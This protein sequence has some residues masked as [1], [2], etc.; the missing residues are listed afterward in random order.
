M[1]VEL[2]PNCSE[3]AAT[4][5]I[6]SVAYLDNYISTPG[7]QECVNY[8]GDIGASPLNGTTGSYAFN[9][10]SGHNFVVVVNAVNTPTSQCSNYSAK[11]S[12]FFDDTPANGA[13]PACVLTP[14][15]TTS[16]LWPPNHNLINVGLASPSTG[17]CPANRQVTVYSDEDDVTPGT[18][19][20]HSPDAKNI[21][22][23]TLRL[24]SERKDSGDG[25]V[26][27]IVVKTSDGTGN[28]AF[29]C[30]T[31]TVPTGQSSAEKNA[32]AAQAAAAQ[33]FCTN[34]AGA[35]PAGF[36]VVGDGPVIG[37]KQ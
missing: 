5:Q 2:T 1:T 19:G 8:L 3:P 9:V 36:F 31:V 24:R 10:P 14:T 16:Q 6:F 12:G 23:G 13:C 17:I 11:I 28:G 32:V 20:E 21:A 30:K 4:N 29:A 27:L 7:T 37:P 34:N 35:A 22:L 26:Y 25:R 15:T 18:S 33:T